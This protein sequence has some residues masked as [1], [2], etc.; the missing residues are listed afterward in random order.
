MTSGNFFRRSIFGLQNVYIFQYLFMKYNPNTYWAD[1]T[2]TMIKISSM[3][4][5][6]PSETNKI[7]Y[8]VTISKF[9]YLWLL[10]GRTSFELKSWIRGCITVTWTEKLPMKFSIY[11]IRLYS[12]QMCTVIMWILG[13]RTLVFMA[14]LTLN[15]HS[16]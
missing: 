15:P 7:L 4:P 10:N 3:S 6:T 2:K 1:L 5:R 9:F 12:L 16:S 14:S 8:G 13:T 11:S